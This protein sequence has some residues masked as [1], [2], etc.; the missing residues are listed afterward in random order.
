M[1]K[2]RVGRPRFDSKQGRG[3]DFSP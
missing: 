2:L 3:R 1:T